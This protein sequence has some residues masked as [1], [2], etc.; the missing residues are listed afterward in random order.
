MSCE[1]ALSWVAQDDKRVGT[2]DAMGKR[3]N[4]IYSQRDQTR[5]T[6]GVRIA[7]VSSSAGCDEPLAED[8][9]A[10]AQ[11]GVKAILEIRMWAE[12]EKVIFRVPDLAGINPDRDYRSCIGLEWAIRCDSY[13]DE[14]YGST[15]PRDPLAEML[16]RTTQASDAIHD[17]FWA[18]SS[19]IMRTKVPRRCGRD[20]MRA[21][22][23]IHRR[24]AGGGTGC[25]QTGSAARGRSGGPA[26]QKRAA[27]QGKSGGKGNKGKH[28]EASS[29]GRGKDKP[30][31]PRSDKGKKG[32]GK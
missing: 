28:R 23:D 20:A 6:V 29:E 25:P 9:L 32:D 11:N 12:Y 15:L 7:Q 1:N 24:G 26:A 21:S 2:D 8:I 17:W 13:W 14:K 3:M 16:L 30:R 31:T 19:S 22:A 5:W 10:Q 4:H 27:S 18:S